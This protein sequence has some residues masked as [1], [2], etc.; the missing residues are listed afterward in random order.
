MLTDERFVGMDVGLGSAGVGDDD[1]GEWGNDILS[2][3]A[4]ATNALIVVE[5]PASTLG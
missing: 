2:A 3:Q 4:V 5:I 1:V